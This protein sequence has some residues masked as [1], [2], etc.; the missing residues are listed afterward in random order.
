[1]DPVAL[2]TI[3]VGCML[4][5]LG[6]GVP[7][8]FALAFIGTL[9]Y[10]FMAGWQPAIAQL[11]LIAFDKGTDFVMVCVPLFI[12][13]GQ[14]VLHTNLASD[15]Y[16]CLQTWVGR[17]R[18]GLAI[19]SVGACGGF[20]AV[21]G[22]SAACVATMASI[23]MPEMRRYKYSDRLASGVLAASGTLGILIPPS[24]GFVF[25]GILTDTSI[26]DLFIA[27][28][29]PGVLTILLYCGSIYIR[30]LVNPDLAPRGPRYTYRQ[31]LSSLR[32]LI[33][34]LIVFV[35]V[36]GGLYGGV[37]TPTEGAGIG[38]AGV[39]LVS[40][41]M[42]RISIERIK[43]A[44]YETGV[45]SAMIFAIIIG[46]YMLARFLALTQITQSMIDIVVAMKMGRVS[47]IIAMILVYLIL[48]MMLD[49][50]GMLV[51]SIPFFFPVTLS[52]GI[53]PVWFGVFVVIMTEIAMVT[54]PIGTNV[55]ILKTIVPD[56][57]MSEVF[58]G[59]IW[60]TVCDLSLV[61]LL[62]VFPQIAL[63]LPRLGR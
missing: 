3:G 44:L 20:G 47:F 1:M 17:L 55:F 59:I 61:F 7:I 48:G 46:G 39:C 58:K 30:V 34:I 42:R 60:F 12:L 2:G 6:L 33:P 51:L 56:I 8:A 9:G 26:G 22:S 40:L 15:L 63:W 19:A 21:T 29:V 45:L 23:I 13:M 5:L 57:P 36:I 62:I 32:G 16:F 11:S 35:L 49:I 38:V 37:F 18:G 25:Y 4:G 24:L 52:M 50:F 10:V 54:P 27:G 43:R 14:L 28:I 31:R 53:D 41:A